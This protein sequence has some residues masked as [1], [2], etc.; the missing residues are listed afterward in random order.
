[1]SRAQLNLAFP[2]RTNAGIS[3]D[4]SGERVVAASRR[5]DGTYRKEIKI[6]PGFTPQEDVVLYRSRGQAEAERHRAVKG[7]VPGLKPGA[8]V[9]AGRGAGASAQVQAALGGMGKAARKNAKRKEKRHEDAAAVEGAGAAVGVRRKDEEDVPDAWDAEEEQAPS[10]AG[11][12]PPAVPSIVPAPAAEAGAAELS[13]E[14]KEKKARALRKKLRQAE[15]LRDRPSPA[16]SLSAA[17][18]EKVDKI[19]EL[20]AELAKLAV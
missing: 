8:A 10:A 3:K 1:M 15:Q 14:E 2:D 17:E 16:A 7:S 13:A 18:Q 9:G 5:P 12:L 6:R 4:A 11:A 20:E 19:T